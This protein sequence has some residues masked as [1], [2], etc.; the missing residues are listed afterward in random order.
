MRITRM[1]GYR[2]VVALML[3]LLLGHPARAALNSTETVR[4]RAPTVSD[5]AIVATTGNPM[6]GDTLQSGGSARF[7]DVDGDSEVNSLKQWYRSGGTTPVASGTSYRLTA[8]DAGHTLQFGY[9]PAT[10]PSIT[11]PAVGMEVRSA[12]SAVV[13]GLPVA[14]GSAFAVSK[15]SV[16]A[17]N[18]DSTVLTLTL[19]DSGGRPVTGIA[20]RLSLVASVV[21][22]FSG[23]A[24]ALVQPAETAPG[25]GIYRVTV[26][27]GTA[28][29]LT[30]TPR[31]N[32]GPLSVTPGTQ[33]ITF[34]SPPSVTQVSPVENAYSFANNSGFPTT[35]FANARFKVSL[36]DNNPTAY[37]WAV[38]GS[39]NGTGYTSVDTTGVVTLNTA[40]SGPQVIQVK[41]KISGT[42][43]ASYTFTLNG[44][45]TNNGNTP[46]NWPSSNAYCSTRGGLATRAQLANGTPGYRSTRSVGNL[47]GE[48]GYMESQG[49]GFLSLN[50]WASDGDGLG[51]YHT[52]FLLDGHV[53]NANDTNRRYVTCR[54]G[55]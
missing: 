54:Q 52:V 36:S 30:V 2:P 44:W 27:S 3:G 48:W 24:P 8:D 55:L 26:A 9:T 45:F 38:D 4:G 13:Q 1:T 21:S 31:L 18:S 10:D 40:R 32:G 12:A 50:Y 33:Q 43:F 34:V 17:N 6:E 15:T 5:V 51:V 49:S 19:K 23:G 29:T 39:N 46:L 11:D 7:A 47:W 14:A 37:Q 41:D 25:S 28:G 20:T 53:S 22:G 35:G 16:T 42:V